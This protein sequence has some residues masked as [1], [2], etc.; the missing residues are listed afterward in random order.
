MLVSV[1]ADT[2]SIAELEQCL[3][4]SGL[5]L[6]EFS[7]RCRNWLEQRIG[8]LAEDMNLAMLLRAEGLWPDGTQETWREPEAT[9]RVFEQ[10]IGEQSIGEQSIG[11]DWEVHLRLCSDSRIACWNE[12]FRNCKQATDIL[13]F[14]FAVP[15]SSGGPGGDLLLSLHSWQAN[16]R[17]FGCDPDEELC[18]LLLHG[19]LHLTGWDHYADEEPRVPRSPMLLYQENLLKQHSQG[20]LQQ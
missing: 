15:E 12:Q 2:P 7:R 10:S 18:R 13:S 14:P 8:L 17:E 1:Q 19:L 16:S 9:G 6:A 4:T 5:S 20:I 3:Q 11:T